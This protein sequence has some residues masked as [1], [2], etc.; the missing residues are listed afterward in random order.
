MNLLLCLE[1]ME[2]T[3]GVSTAQCEFQSVGGVIVSN[4]PFTVH[5]ASQQESA[6]P[7]VSAPSFIS[8]VCVSG[9]CGTKSNCSL[10]PV[11]KP[12]NE[13]NAQV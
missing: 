5:A 6:A 1:P 2:Q 7:P 11:C 9:V 4:Y 3:R 12:V 13:K 8:C 10:G